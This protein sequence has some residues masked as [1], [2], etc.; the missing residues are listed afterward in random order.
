MRER[1]LEW[2]EGL[3]VAEIAEREQKH[4]V[5]AMLDVAGEKLDTTYV[6]PWQPIDMTEMKRVANSP[7]AL[8]GTSDGGAHTKFL[9]MATYPTY[10]LATLARDNEI[11]DL[12]QAHWRLS[13]Y[14]ALAAGFKDRGWIREGAPADLIV[15]DLDKLEIL[16]REM[17]YDQPAGSWRRVQRSQGYRWV[18]VNGEIT[19][20]DGQCTGATPGTLLR[21]GAAAP[22]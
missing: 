7:F 5:D 17:V 15:Y 18:M 10:Y 11:M 3:T 22:A 21:H 4:V 12:E 16:P 20:E 6:T 19:F 14:P 1:E 8:P 13:A 2:S 9:T